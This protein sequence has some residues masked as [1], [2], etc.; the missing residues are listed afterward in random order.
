MAVQIVIAHP[1]AHSRLL[2]AVVAECH[3]AQHTFFAE[4]SIVVVHEKQTRGGIAGN[5]D[6]GPS[7]F[8]EIG[9]DYRHP[10]G[11]RRARNPR[12]LAHVGEGPVA[13]VTV[14]R[15][16]SGGQSARSALN[17]DALPIAIYVLARHRRVLERETYI[18][19]NEEIEVAI[20]IVVKETASRSPSRLIVQQP[21]G[22]RDVGKRSI[23][24]IA[25]KTVLPEA[26]A[27]DILKPVV[28]VVPDADTGGPAYGTQAGLLGHIRK[29][30][31]PIVLV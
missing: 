26:G 29:S 11:P 4:R 9:S 21:G 12:L 16:S 5:K 24:I 27:E 22:F 14:S 30:T 3:S 28:V 7:V 23:S 2:H 13:V 31:V 20:P 19:G 1:N 10:I 15:V 18:V 17:R 8:V 25:I 6:V